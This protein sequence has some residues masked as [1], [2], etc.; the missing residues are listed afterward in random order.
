MRIDIK[1]TSKFPFLKFAFVPTSYVGIDPASQA[2]V[3]M[4]ATAPP[5]RRYKTNV[6]E[7]ALEDA[8][9]WR[10]LI[11]ASA[12]ETPRAQLYDYY[13][14]AMRD[15]VVSGLTQELW[16]LTFL[17]GAR[18]TP[19]SEMRN[20][21]PEA[22][23]RAVPPRHIET[24]NT[25][26]FETMLREVFDTAFWGISLMRFF[27]NADGSV[28]TIVP[29][30]RKNI[31]PF[32]EQY[33]S[34]PI[35][36]NSDNPAPKKVSYKNN[37]PQT[38]NFIQILNNLD[39]N[40]F[41]IL[42]GLTYLVL[43]KRNAEIL[44]GINNENYTHV[45]SALKMKDFNAL[46]PE[47][48]DA[49]RQDMNNLPSVRSV[50]FSKPDDTIEFLKP[51]TAFNHQTLQEH[52]NH[53]DNQ[54]KALVFSFI[55]NSERNVSAQ[56]ARLSGNLL[57]IKARRYQITISKFVNEVVFPYLSQRS[58]YYRGL[59]RYVYEII[60]IPDDDLRL[61]TDSVRTQ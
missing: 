23:A 53:V 34:F 39:I 13:A 4:D 45:L 11:V 44:W 10:G 7:Q 33:F 16:D 59:T 56:E 15:C 31:N 49:W 32:A 21:V 9:N 19:K 61:S 41:G 58:S 8:K 30:N 42:E 54:I 57:S 51:T 6:Y 3:E 14:E 40:N 55:Q 52:I 60:P 46:T 22:E 50:I 18:L 24:I 28:S 36:T 17:R 25:L 37:N 43:Q 5:N 26:W 12:T 20:G 47:Q 38:N 48:R 29:I 1:T 27:W 2:S 35:N